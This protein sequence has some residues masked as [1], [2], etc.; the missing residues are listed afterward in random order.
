MMDI[1]EFKANL[2]AT[3]SFL[4]A[5]KGER[6]P[7]GFW[8]QQQA[9]CLL[10]GEDLWELRGYA[11]TFASLCGMKSSAS[12]PPRLVEDAIW[13]A[14]D[15]CNARSL[16]YKERTSLEHV[17]FYAVCEYLNIFHSTPKSASVSYA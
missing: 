1:H 9:L 5:K 7:L 2:L 14:L 8:T 11:A 4:P 13:R 3:I 10:E 15:P 17:A 12:V 16:K 6:S